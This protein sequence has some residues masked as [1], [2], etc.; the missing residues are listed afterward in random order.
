MSTTGSRLQARPVFPMHSALGEPKAETRSEDSMLLAILTDCGLQVR[1]VRP[2]P[3]GEQ[4]ILESVREIPRHFRDHRLSRTLQ[5]PG[6]IGCATG[7]E[8]CGVQDVSSY[9]ENEASAH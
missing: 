5:K 9:E 1:D 8:S 2:L 3:S 6:T 4:A 7:R